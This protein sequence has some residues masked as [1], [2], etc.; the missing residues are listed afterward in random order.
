[1]ELSARKEQPYCILDEYI[2][3][4]TLEYILC[5]ALYF[6]LRSVYLWIYMLVHNNLSKS[7]AYDID[8]VDKLEICNGSPM[9]S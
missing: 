2:L 3:C 1:M 8:Y 7:R 5:N 9:V 4:N 6:P